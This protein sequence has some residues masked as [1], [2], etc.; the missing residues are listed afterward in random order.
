MPL[1][2]CV[3]RRL[4]HYLT[5]GKD[6]HEYAAKSPHVEVLRSGPKRCSVPPSGKGPSAISREKLCSSEAG[7]VNT[8]TLC[9][10]RHGG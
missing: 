6:L 9:A 5:V 8:N 1:W 4:L 3:A 10:A 2:R 7:T